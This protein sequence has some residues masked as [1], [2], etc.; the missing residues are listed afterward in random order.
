LRRKGRLV[1][2]PAYFESENTR[3][4]GRRVPQGLALRGVKVDELYKA[5]EDLELN[6][7][8]KPGTAFSKQPWDRT[9]S[10]IVDKAKSETLITAELASRIRSNRSKR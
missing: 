7:E 2:W 4:K 5:A 6:P 8:L 10:V 9:G 3:G 1:F